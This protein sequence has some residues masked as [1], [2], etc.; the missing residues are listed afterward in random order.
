M[1]IIKVLTIAISSDFLEWKGKYIGMNI[2]LVSLY[3]SIRFAV[4]MRQFAI[5]ASVSSRSGLVTG[6]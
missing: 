6:H 1:D 3:L 5:F 4:T 2:I